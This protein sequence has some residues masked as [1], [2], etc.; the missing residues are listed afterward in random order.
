MSFKNC[1]CENDVLPKAISVDNWVYIKLAVITKCDC[2][3]DVTDLRQH[4]IATSTSAK[5]TLFTFSC[6]TFFQ[7]FMSLTIL[8]MHDK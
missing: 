7:A 1:V 2:L 3:N 4:T 5:K 6:L 8:M